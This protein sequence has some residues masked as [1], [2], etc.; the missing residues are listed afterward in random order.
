MVGAWTIALFFTGRKHAGEDGPSQR[1][2]E[3]SIW[4]GSC[5]GPAPTALPDCADCRNSGGSPGNPIC[6]SPDGC[7]SGSPLGTAA[8]APELE[9]RKGRPPILRTGLL[10]ILFGYRNRAG[11]PGF[12]AEDQWHCE[13][14]PEEADI[15][16]AD[17]ER[18]TRS[19]PPSWRNSAPAGTTMYGRAACC[20][21]SSPVPG[22]FDEGWM[23]IVGQTEPPKTHWFKT[24]GASLSCGCPVGLLLGRPSLSLRF[25]HPLPAGWRISA[26]SSVA[27][28]NTP[29]SN[30]RWFAWIPSKHPSQPESHR[31]RGKS[32]YCKRGASYS[33]GIGMAKY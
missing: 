2:T 31:W 26:I 14:S 27:P 22:A 3:S 12:V 7:G 28:A 18:A 1:E 16:W 32:G 9:A 11:V 21:R 23:T 13:G 19:S 4:N 30:G 15:G 29:G 10:T 6:C 24:R 8:R 17:A 25:G 20:G 5:R 33:N